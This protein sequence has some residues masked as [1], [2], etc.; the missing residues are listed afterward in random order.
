MKSRRLGK[1]LKQ[2][3]REIRAKLSNIN[4][5]PRLHRGLTKVKKLAGAPNRN[6]KAAPLPQSDS[7]GEPKLKAKRSQSLVFSV[8]KLDNTQRSSSIN[9]AVPPS[10]LTS[11]PL[12]S[13]NVSN[14]KP[15]AKVFIGDGSI[16]KEKKAPAKKGTT[17][18]KRGQAEKKY[19][20]EELRNKIAELHKQTRT[21]RV[22][23]PAVDKL[24]AEV[25]ESLKTIEALD[26]IYCNIYQEAKGR[27]RQLK[28]EF[29]HLKALREQIVEYYPDLLSN[30]S[31]SSGTISYETI[32]TPRIPEQNELRFASNVN[33]PSD[34]CYFLREVD[35]L[36]PPLIPEVV[37]WDLV[38]R[39]NKNQV[40]AE[41]LSKF[42]CQPTGL[43]MNIS[44][45]PNSKP[46]RL[47]IKK[48]QQKCAARRRTRPNF[49]R[50]PPAP[51]S[52]SYGACAMSE[53]LSIGSSEDTSS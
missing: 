17:T 26:K 19:S 24:I 18:V 43:A 32:I 2:M 6:P 37:D 52:R 15:A 47:V 33:E 41:A 12:T 8:G 16:E 27:T 50:F 39:F 25:D 21:L 23:D 40:I 31:N 11:T 13:T 44:T 34:Q 20:N 38:K 30:Y 48:R 9:L 14:E 46:A 22:E 29:E 7:S 51:E 10:T 53:E 35:L 42:L 28:I 3:N 1:N 5:K 36:P 45:V 4:R 49:P